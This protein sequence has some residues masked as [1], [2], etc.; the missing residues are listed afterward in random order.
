MYLRYKLLWGRQVQQQRSVV[1][2]VT[3]FNL[4]ECTPTRGSPDRLLVVLVMGTKKIV[5]VS[6][7]GRSLVSGCRADVN[8]H[9]QETIQTYPSSAS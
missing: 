5:H 7:V 3:K 8:L 2:R 9:F 1:D 4:R 6:T